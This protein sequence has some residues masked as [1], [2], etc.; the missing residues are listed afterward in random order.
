MVKETGR[1][2]GVAAEAVV[3][4][5]VVV[6][7]GFARIGG[8]GCRARSGEGRMNGRFAL[9]WLQANVSVEIFVFVQSERQTFAQA[10]VYTRASDGMRVL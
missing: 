7:F 1:T 5:M 8:R 9:I 6:Y 2:A 3:V 4:A 10:R